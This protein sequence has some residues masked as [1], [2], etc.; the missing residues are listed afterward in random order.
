M[1]VNARA[2]VYRIPDSKKKLKGK[3]DTEKQKSSAV[4]GINQWNNV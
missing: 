1:F 3:T 4:T 2:R